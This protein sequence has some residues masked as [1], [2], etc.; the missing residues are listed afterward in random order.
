MDNFT[1]VV[2]GGI[3]APSGSANLAVTI[4][5]NQIF[6]GSVTSPLEP[7]EHDTPLS[8][9]CRWTVNESLAGTATVQ[10]NTDATQSF[11]SM[12]GQETSYGNA[13]N[14]V[15]QVI[16]LEYPDPEI[17]SHAVSNVLLDGISQPTPI[18]TEKP[19]TPDDIRGWHYRFD[20]KT[21]ECDYFTGPF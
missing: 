4:N 15:T 5:G 1:Y 13:G 10:I 9:L 18:N 21:F 2:L 16:Q 3:Y 11:F 12:L 19:E 7:I 8:E 6:N 14:I 17:N 20:G